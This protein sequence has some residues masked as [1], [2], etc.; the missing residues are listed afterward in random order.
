M[1]VTNRVTLFLSEGATASFVYPSRYISVADFFEN[2]E[3]VIMVMWVVGAFVKITVFYFVS[4]LSTDR[5]A[6]K[7][8]V[9]LKFIKT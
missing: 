2:V 1:V 6:D 9:V 3:S 7:L 8:D 5:K 4:V